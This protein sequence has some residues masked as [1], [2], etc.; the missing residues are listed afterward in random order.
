[1]DGNL[2]AVALAAASSGLVT[3]IIARAS[4]GYD[5]RSAA[6]AALIGTG[7]TIIAEQNRRIQAI[8]EDNGRLWA[9]VQESYQRERECRVEISELQNQLSEQRHSVR[10]LEQKVIALERKLDRQLGGLD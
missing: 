7:P 6:E 5:A 1:M 3:F 2:W 4:K 9:Q 8:Q 10:D